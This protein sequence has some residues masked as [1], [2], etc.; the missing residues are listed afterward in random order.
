MNI[1]KNKV[2]KNCMIPLEVVHNQ[3]SMNDLM[4][5][6]VQLS[7]QVPLLTQFDANKSYC[8]TLLVYV[9]S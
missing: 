6:L 4:T 5:R 1:L 9:S 2:S 3:S 8:V 7:K